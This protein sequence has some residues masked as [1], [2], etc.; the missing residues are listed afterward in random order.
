MLERLPGGQVSYFVIPSGTNPRQP[1]DENSIEA[2]FDSI[3][4][5]GPRKE[6]DNFAIILAEIQTEKQ[7]CFISVEQTACDSIVS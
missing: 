2:G 4:R 1:S 7:D 6:M 3:R 5:E